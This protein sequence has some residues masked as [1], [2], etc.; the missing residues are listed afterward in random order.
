MAADE[1][2]KFAGEVSINK[3]NVISSSGFY[4]DIKNQVIGIQVFEDLMSPFITGTLIIKDALDLINLFPFVGEEFV[5]LDISTPTLKQGNIKATFYIFKMTDRQML[6]DKVVVYQLHFI[7]KEAIT[8]VNKSISK[9]FGGK[10][11]DIATKLLTSKTDGLQLTN[12]PKPIVETTSNETKYISNYWSPIKN[13]LYLTG[14]AKNRKG[15]PTYVF[16]ENRDGYNFVSLDSLFKQPSVQ[17]FVKDNYVRD[18][19]ALSGSIKNLEEDYRR[20]TSISIPIGVDYLDRIQS[21]VYASKLITHD[22]TTKV[23]S[24]NNYNMFDNFNKRNHLN[25]NAAASKN[26][27]YRYGSKI[28]FTGKYYGNFSNYGDVTSAAFEQER[29]SY[30]KMLD[31]TK[32]QITVPGRMDYTV[33]RVVE[34]N[35]NKNEPTTKADDKTLD[36]MFSGRYIITA[37][38]HFID[39]EKH[40]CQL[41]LSK[42][43]LLVNLDGTKIK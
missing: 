9:T 21:G 33:G 43:S 17:S 6:G 32:I 4:Q 38:N 7:S 39:R 3:V 30:L 18:D 31:S 15:S 24:S 12:T 35:L 1:L 19:R 20:I 10:V 29:T 40:E 11:S 8:D 28:L 42:D 22:L 14:Q 13:I 2:L 5:E 25:K 23:I 27:I 34:V 36:N 16:F 37:I 26:V 41:E